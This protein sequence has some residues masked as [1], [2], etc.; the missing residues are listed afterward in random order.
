M[1]P[2]FQTLPEVRKVSYATNA[3]DSL[4]MVMRR[5][6]RNRRILPND[7]AALKAVFTAIREASK[8]WKMFRHRKRAL[9]TFQL[10]LGEDRVPLAAL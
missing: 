5:Y 4:N 2:F 10:L 8:N 3:I 7:D 6:T 9:Q 1:T